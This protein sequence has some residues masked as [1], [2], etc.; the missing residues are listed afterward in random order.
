L[1]LEGSQSFHS[2]TFSTTLSWSSL[3]F[4]ANY[5]QGSG[6]SVLSSGGIVPVPPTSGIL[7]ADLIA[8]TARNYGAGLTWTPI[9]N[10]VLSG[11]YSRSISDTLSANTPSHNN[12]EIFYSQMQYNLRRIGIMAGYTRFTQGISATGIAPGTISSFY[13]G[14]TRWF[15]FF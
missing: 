5:A 13:G 8:Y 10:M 14:I 4:T 11:T 7:P 12:T 2:E 1:S 3:G 6:N 9:R 15:N